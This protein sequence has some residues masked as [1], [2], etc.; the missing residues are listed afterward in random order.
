ME[1]INVPQ[2]DKTLTE[3][4]ITEVAT[5][6]AFNFLVRIARDMGSSVITP[7]G[8]M[9]LPTQKLTQDFKDAC[10]NILDALQPPPDN[11]A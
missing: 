7:M 4:Q 2:D 5:E 10:K 9:Y 11:A 6:N 1:N 3:D 8:L